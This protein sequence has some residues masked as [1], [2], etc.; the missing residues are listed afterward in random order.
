MAAR[1]PQSGSSVAYKIKDAYAGKILGIWWAASADS[2]HQLLDGD[3]ATTIVTRASSSASFD[4]GEGLITG[5]ESSEFQIEQAGGLGIAEGDSDFAIGCSYFGDCFSGVGSFHGIGTIP[6]PD[7]FSNGTRIRFNNYNVLW[8]ISGGNGEGH[9]STLSNN[10]PDW[11]TLFMRYDSDNATAKIMTWLNGTEL[12]ADRQN[13]AAPSGSANWGDTGRPLGFGATAATNATT[14]ASFEAAFIGTGLSDAEMAA[15]SADPSSVIEVYVAPPPD[16]EVPV[17]AMVM[18]DYAP[19]VAA[20]TLLIP[21]SAMTMAALTPQVPDIPDGPIEIPVDATI[22]SGL[23][24]TIPPSIVITDF[25]ASG[26]DL[27]IEYSTAGEGGTKTITLNYTKDSVGQTPVN[28]ATVDGTLT[29]SDPGAGVYAITT[30]E[31]EDSI[32]TYTDTS[33]T[34]V[35]IVGSGG[36][37]EGTVTIEIPVS[38]TVLSAYDPSVPVAAST[39][40]QVQ[41]AT[42]LVEAH[43]PSLEEAFSENVVVPVATMHMTVNN[44]SV[45]QLPVF[46]PTASMDVES[47]TPTMATA[48][49]RFHR[50]RIRADDG[51]IVKERDF[52]IYII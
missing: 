46:I 29:I 44:P 18:A 37:D 32:G 33:V 31:V 25:Y 16:I 2:V 48:T 42:L 14:Y 36:E 22:L 26:S 41:T 43:Q 17:A 9:G 8:N 49:R 34:T 30:L 51:E 13:T 39:P 12:S 11:M 23:T 6:Y 40:I 3:T 24:P 7:T 52:L 19:T 20:A 45:L 27:I 4:S 5:S 15:V 47:L 21:S 35:E 38:T 28:D 1:F 10:V 50:V